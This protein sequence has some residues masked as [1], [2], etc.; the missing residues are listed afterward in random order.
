MAIFTRGGKQKFIVENILHLVNN[1]I[2]QNFPKSNT[3]QMENRLCIDF[4]RQFVYLT[5]YVTISNFQYNKLLGPTEIR[6]LC[7]IELL[8]LLLDQQDQKRP[9]FSCSGPGYIDVQV[10]LSNRQCVLFQVQSCWP[11]EGNAAVGYA[12]VTLTSQTNESY[13]FTINGSANNNGATTLIQYA[14]I[15]FLGK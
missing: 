15:V 3:I 13:V 10:D 4:P 1:Q 11:N 8:I 14:K 2:N 5:N 9:T 7:T 12:G 6:R